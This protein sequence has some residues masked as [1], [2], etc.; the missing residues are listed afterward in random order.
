V[1]RTE[2]RLLRIGDELA[3]L[4]NEEELAAGELNMH[5]HIDDDMRRDAAVSEAP[6]DRADAYQSGKDVAR[7]ERVLT[8][9]NRR[10]ARLEERRRRLL[11][12]L[13]D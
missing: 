8:R 4:K 12:R 3:R 1:R 9:I 13:G 10:R 2:R 7:F 6:A 11:G 5:R